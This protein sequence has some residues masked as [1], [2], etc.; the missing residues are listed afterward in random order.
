MDRLFGLV[1]VLLLVAVALPTV[2]GY[3]TRA[4]PVLT[5]ILVL[6]GAVRLLWPSHRKS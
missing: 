5:S 2:A 6:L 4:I 1:L 3:A